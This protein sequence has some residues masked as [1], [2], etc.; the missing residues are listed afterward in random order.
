MEA[1]IVVLQDNPVL[2]VQLR[3]LDVVLQLGAEV[4]VGDADPPVALATMVLAA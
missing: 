3:A 4:A 2:V 1:F